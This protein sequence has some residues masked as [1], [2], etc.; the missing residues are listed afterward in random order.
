MEEVSILMAMSMFQ[1]GPG[2][3]QFRCEA[4]RP[5]LS[6]RGFMHAATVAYPGVGLGQWKN[7][8]KFV[9]C[10]LR[11]RAELSAMLCMPKHAALAAELR[12][13][14]RS[15]GFAV[16]PYVSST[17]PALRRFSE[18]SDHMQALRTDMSVLAPAN[19]RVLHVL[20]LGYLLPTLTLNLDRVL[21][22]SR[23]GCLAF[24]LF[25]EGERMMTIAF[26][27]GTVD[28]ER[29]VYVGGIQGSR[30]DNA[31]E[32]YRVISKAMFAM[33]SRDFLIKV[34]QLLMSTLGVKRIFCVSEQCRHH[35][36]VYFGKNQSVQ[37]RLNYDQVWA[38]H[39]AVRVS[40]EFHELAMLPLERNLDDIPSQDRST[41]R[42]RYA[43][44]RRLRENL[45][46]R[47]TD[48]S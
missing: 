36:H 23:E 11:F 8:L 43:L 31:L 2:S 12:A 28:G 38:E 21:W 37:V 34:F 19:S 42:K 7:R 16:W 24:N 44:M 10:C 33:R 6:L 13:Q 29:V 35:R 15:L 25:Y 46:R 40:E 45:Q 39:S 14:P 47:F 26:A 5:D 18:L 4:A 3:M 9:L 48:A 22:F 30:L 17:W 41:Y 20:D 27:F 1:I 32:I